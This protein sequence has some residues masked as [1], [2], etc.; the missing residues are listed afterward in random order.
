M[1]GCTYTVAYPA[2]QPPLLLL[3]VAEL[4]GLDSKQL[5]FCVEGEQQQQQTETKGQGGPQGCSSCVGPIFTLCAEAPG[6][7][8]MAGRLPEY[9]AAKLIS[10]TTEKGIQLLPDKEGDSLF[11]SLLVLLGSSS[12]SSPRCLYISEGVSLSGLKMLNTYL[13]LRTF[14]LG[15][16]L[17]LAD[18]GVYV[19]LRT[20]AGADKTGA[21]PDQ[22]CTDFPCVVR[23]YC[24]LHALK[25][26]RGPV[27]LGLKQ[28]ALKPKTTKPAAAAAADKA[29]AA[30]I[31]GEQ[32]DAQA[33]YEG[34]SPSNNSRS[35]LQGAEMGK[36]VTRFPP[37]PSGYLHIGHAKAAM[38]NSYFAKK[39]QGQMILR[40][41]F[42][43]SNSSCCCS[44][45]SSSSTSSRSGAA[46]QQQRDEQQQQRQQDQQQQH[47]Q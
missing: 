22:W 41:A 15:H 26:V 28:K 35:K 18:L 3:C 9:E 39:Y 36:V 27:E 17:S 6:E 16:R 44:T 43:S 10:L 1:P 46:A 34:K 42:C 45:G 8:K 14:L 11:S 2:E 33:S 40:S 32:A 12:S 25:E 47:Q 7:T 19:H 37:E 20:I 29:A 13:G 23:W 31:K 5:R 21:L 24:Y 30:K 38:L 4:Q